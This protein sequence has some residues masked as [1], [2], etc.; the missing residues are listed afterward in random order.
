MLIDSV[1]I[2]RKLELI[3]GLLLIP[4]ALL[5]WLFVQQSFKDIE[6]A[7]KERDGVAYASATWPVLKALIV[8]S[9]DS[10]TTPAASMRNAPDIAAL[11]RAY[12]QVMDSGAAA[13]ELSEALRGLAWPNRALSRNAE[14]EKAI[15]AARTL[16]GKIADGSNLTLDPDLD[17]FYVMDIITTKLTELVDREGT[18]VALAIAQHA[19]TSLS[20]DEKSELMIELGQFESALSGASSSLESAYKGNPD[21]S[22]RINLDMPQRPSPTAAQR[23]APK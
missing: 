16:V 15:A 6:F 10:R 8:A 18:L 19:K 7:K 12:D 9:N 22:V 11:G 4:I 14:T 2:K 21:G 3:V 17:S 23:L 1:K 5:A 20:D 13:T